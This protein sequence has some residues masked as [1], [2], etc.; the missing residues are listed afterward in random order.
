MIADIYNK[1]ISTFHPSSLGYLLVLFISSAWLVCSV[2]T[3]QDN[4]FIFFPL[5][6]N[7]IQSLRYNIRHTRRDQLLTKRP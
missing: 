2:V 4:F 7:F 1:Y 3:D 6:L 5:Q